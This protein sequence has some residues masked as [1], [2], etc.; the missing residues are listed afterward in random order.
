MRS[1]II[2]A[3]LAITAA[4]PA[5]AQQDLAGA[6]SMLNYCKTVLAGGQKGSKL[7]RGACIGNVDAIIALGKTLPGPA[8]RGAICAPEAA[9]RNQAIQIVVTYL[10]KTPQAPQAKFVPAAVAALSQA[11]PC[12]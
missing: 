7:A 10:E 12:K 5:L 11:W 2:L 3:T 8:G 9:N 6:S 1:A 4:G